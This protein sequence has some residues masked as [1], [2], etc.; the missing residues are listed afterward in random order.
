MHRLLL[1]TAAVAALI[2]VPGI[3]AA[4]T[5]EAVTDLNMRTGPGPQ[6]PIIG[7]IDANASVGINGCTETR[8]WCQVSWAGQDGWAYAAYLAPTAEVVAPAPAQPR[9]VYSDP[10]VQA[11]V[12]T[13][14][15]GSVAGGAVGGAIVGA[16]V[17]GPVGAAV[18]AAAGAGAGAVVNPP[19]QV[20]T[21]VQTNAVEPVY[22]EGEVVVGAQ[23]P[24]TVA[25]Y[26]VPQY[27]YRYAYVNGQPVIVDPG[28][29]Q[30]VYVVR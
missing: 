19:E 3:A 14:E 17:A 18:G 11:P 9:V 10:Q 20:T 29:H 23:V 26:E 28:S 12:V 4:A 2:A 25:L 7:T 5:A 13:Y 24:Q 8:S 16:L 30:I 15:R 21:Y 6:Y 22:L 1:S 27:E